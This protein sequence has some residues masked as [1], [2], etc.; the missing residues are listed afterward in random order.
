MDNLYTYEM[1]IKSKIYP[2]IICKDKKGKIQ[3]VNRIYESKYQGYVQVDAEYYNV[4]MFVDLPIEIFGNLYKYDYADLRY[5]VENTD[6]NAKTINTHHSAV[7]AL[8]GAYDISEETELLEIAEL[9][10][11][12]MFEV[13]STIVYAHINKWQIMKR[14]NNLLGAEMNQIR[15]ILAEYEEDNSI[16]C[17]CYALLDD[18]EKAQEY[19]EKMTE[20]ERNQFKIVPIYKYVV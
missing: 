20:E 6:F 2:F 14:K 11:N 8:I 16:Q 1:K 5:Q 18:K 12:K 4:P 17:A 9:I 13:D 10:L 3:F 15:G 7:I 19:F